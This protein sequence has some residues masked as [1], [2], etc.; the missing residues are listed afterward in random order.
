MEPKENEEEVHQVSAEIYET[1]L[2]Y[3]SPRLS[4]TNQVVIEFDNLFK[5]E[6]NFIPRLKEP[7]EEM[8][9]TSVCVLNPSNNPKKP[10]LVYAE[11]M[12]KMSIGSFQEQ[13]EWI[14]DINIVKIWVKQ[15]K[16]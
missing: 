2:Q 16:Q 3:M 1:L 9:H 5:V 13:F 14:R 10:V 15:G 11:S 8:L 4:S 6:Q 7:K 12:K